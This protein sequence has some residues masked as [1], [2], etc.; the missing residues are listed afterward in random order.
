MS[1]SRAMDAFSGAAN[2]TAIMQ[3]PC[4]SPAPRG[5]MLT[6]LEAASDLV[7]SH[8]GETDLQRV[9]IEKVTEPFDEHVRQLGIAFAAGTRQGG[10]QFILTVGRRAW[11]RLQSHQLN[12]IG[13]IDRIDGRNAID[14]RDRL[15]LQTWHKAALGAIAFIVD[16]QQGASAGILIASRWHH[17]RQLLRGCLAAW[18]AGQ[19]Q[20]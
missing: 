2:V 8:L 7:G 1:L 18:L 17:T 10:F 4:P 6:F 9:P 11:R 3:L 19:A 20:G 15:L 13:H 14:E 12:A 5:S 16:T